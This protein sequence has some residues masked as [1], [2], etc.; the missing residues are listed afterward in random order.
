M[1]NGAFEDLKRKT[2]MKIRYLK[3]LKIMKI[4]FYNIW[5]QLNRLS[6]E[7]KIEKDLNSAQCLRIFTMILKWMN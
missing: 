1:A 3:N 6:S 5:S 2:K 4:Q 7:S